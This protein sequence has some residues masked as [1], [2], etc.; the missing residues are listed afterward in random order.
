MP[1]TTDA[2]IHRIGRTGRINNTGEAFTLVTSEDKGMI[3]A[4]ERI[5]KKPIETRELPGF[6]YSQP[7]SR[8]GEARKT[9]PAAKRT[10]SRLPRRKPASRG[11]S[12]RRGKTPAGERA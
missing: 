12:R 5:F 4:L 8:A 1:D 11:N 2:Y 3:K 10:V 7:T 6:S 9:R